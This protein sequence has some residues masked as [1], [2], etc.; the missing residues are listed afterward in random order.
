MCS[1]RGPAKATILRLGS[2]GNPETLDQTCLEHQGY[3][4]YMITNYYSGVVLKRLIHLPSRSPK[5][6]PF[7][8][9]ALRGDEDRAAEPQ[10]MQNLRNSLD[11]RPEHRCSKAIQSPWFM[12]LPLFKWDAV[13][14]GAWNWIELIGTYRKKKS[15]TKEDRFWGD[16]NRKPH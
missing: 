3:Y 15:Q 1:G 14:P 9:H 7:P 10:E 4:L 2:G 11:T 6:H 13:S 8:G 16:G 12:L 5:F